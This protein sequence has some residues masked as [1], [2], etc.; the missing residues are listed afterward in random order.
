[1][2]TQLL[3]LEIQTQYFY[4]VCIT[5]YTDFTS[6]LM[7]HNKRNLD[8]HPLLSSPCN[9]SVFEILINKSKA[10]KDT[11]ITNMDVDID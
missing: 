4:D 3:L 1:M 2:T 7:D 10:I 8:N 5:R 6:N 9:G 11:H